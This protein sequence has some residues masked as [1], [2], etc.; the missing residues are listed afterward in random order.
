MIVDRDIEKNIRDKTEKFL[1]RENLEL[2]EFK[3]F[4]K[5]NTYVVRV[6]ADYPQGGITI[7][8]CARLNKLLFS[9]LDGNKILGNDFS[10]EVISPGLDRKLK[11]KKDLLRVKGKPLLVWLSASLEGKTYYEGM[12]LAVEDEGIVL[13]SEGTIKIPHALISCAKQ[14]ITDAFSP[15]K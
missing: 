3:V 11:T 8:D 15:Y 1:T 14:K 10:V 7:A 5:S 2:V 12:L 13:E 4:S 6:V 9:Y